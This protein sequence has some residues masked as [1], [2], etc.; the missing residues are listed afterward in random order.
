MFFRI[1]NTNRANALTFTDH[2]DLTGHLTSLHITGLPAKFRP[3]HSVDKGLNFCALKA[4]AN[5]LSPGH[6]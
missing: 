3:L 6:Q 4:G 2:V 1:N 5:V